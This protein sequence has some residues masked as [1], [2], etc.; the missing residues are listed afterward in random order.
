MSGFDLQHKGQAS[1]SNVSVPDAAVSRAE[2]HLLLDTL[3]VTAVTEA[4]EMASI[5]GPMNRF[6]VSRTAGSSGDETCKKM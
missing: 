5:S 4:R 3:V 6:S 1:H 2:P